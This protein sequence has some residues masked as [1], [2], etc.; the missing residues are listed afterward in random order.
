[1][2]TIIS[3][4]V[5]FLLVAVMATVFV[6]PVSAQPGRGGPRP[7]GPP[8]RPYG[9]PPRHHDDFGKV[10]GVIGA[11]GIAAAFANG[12]S[13]Y[14]YYRYERPVVVVPQ[15]P[16]V[17]VERQQPVVIEK[18][19]V[20]EKPVYIEKTT[21]A[22]TEEYYSP[23][24]GATF[25]IEK[26]QIP[27]YKFTAARL[28]SDPVEGSPLSQLGLKKRDAITR[29]DDE[30]VDSLSVLERHEKNT[31]VRYIKTG[32]VKVQLG[33]MYIPTDSEMTAND[34]EYFAP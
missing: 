5:T 33:K 10:L 3:R 7:Y 22:A 11:V 34:E 20:V 4:S 30:T 25:K 26:M 16:T 8:P 32:T 17:V 2:N 15:Q 21:P 14:R 31:V 28:M 23:K 18:Q 13:P 27:G 19:V 9:P 6:L 24:L 1:M 12:Y 29:L